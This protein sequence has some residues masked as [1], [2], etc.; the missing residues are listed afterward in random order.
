MPQAA[1]ALAKSEDEAVS[2]VRSLLDQLIESREEEK[3]L[4]R[5]LLDLG[6]RE[7]ERGDRMLT[8]LG[9]TRPGLNGR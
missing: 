6:R 3:R 7:V 2:E 1:R 9:L 8:D 5:A 4:R